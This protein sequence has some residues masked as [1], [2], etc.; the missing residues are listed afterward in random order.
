MSHRMHVALWFLIVALACSPALA[1]DEPLIGEDQPPPAPQVEPEP[2]PPPPPAPQPQPQYQPQPQPQPA[3]APAPV[4]SG[5]MTPRKQ[6]DITDTD[7]DMVIRAIGLQIVYIANIAAVVQAQAPPPAA[8][9]EK[10]TEALHY[11]EGYSSPGDGWN[12]AQMGIRAW[13]T[14][15]VGLDAGLSLYIAR[16][17]GED[18]DTQFGFGLFAGVPFALGVYRHLVAFAGP[19]VGF[20]FFHPAEDINHWLFNLGGKAGIEISFGFMD[21]PRLSVIGTM[22]LGLR[23]YNDGDYSE[24]LVANDSGFS[25]NSLFNTSVGLCWYI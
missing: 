17:R 4:M 2:P 24:V 20:G 5:D 7:H 6:K 21:I 23:V 25:I 14:R 8:L 12:Q 3:P 18:M 13:F 22:T 11:D 19:E 10:D 16:P 1:Q 15:G 9:K